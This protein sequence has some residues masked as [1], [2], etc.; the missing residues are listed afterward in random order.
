MQPLISFIL[1]S[2]YPFRNLHLLHLV[3]AVLYIAT[4]NEGMACYKNSVVNYCAVQTGEIF[5]RYVRCKNND[6][7]ATMHTSDHCRS[8][9][10]E[11]Q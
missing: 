9:W 1:P 5:S 3:F 7:L 11:N 8:I 6:R 2:L 10:Y 4:M